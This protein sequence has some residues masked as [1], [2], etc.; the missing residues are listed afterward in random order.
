[1]N[2][3]LFPDS[4]PSGFLAVLYHD[5][6]LL[7]GVAVALLLG[8][9]GLFDLPINVP[10][11]TVGFC[12]TT[13]V[14]AAD[15]VWV[16]SPEDR[17][18]RPE[19]L[20]WIRAHEG[21]LAIETGVLVAGAG[22]ALPYLAWNTLL[23]AGALGSVAV[24][25]ALPRG[26]VRGPS[27]IYK[28]MAIA[29]VW[30]AGGALLP[31]IEAGHPLGIGALLFVGYR[32]CFILPNLLLA[33]W[34]DQVGDAA[35]GLAPWATGWT[36]HRMRGTATAFLLVAA[37][38]GAVWALVGTMPVLIAI[39]ALGPLLMIGGV[40]KLSP[41]RPRDAFLADLAVAWPL[42]PALVAWM[43]V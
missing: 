37:T 3:T 6:A 34:A 41:A 21:W 17:V 39:D 12:G 7:G 27:G 26:W 25:H 43:I 32:L 20:R 13:L 16:E 5:P 35:V 42:I 1:M 2:S 11:L 22:A 18:N 8:T 31:L 15:R 30:A 4:S 10:L 9:C 40:W 38:G 19:R 24:L 36:A 14:Y 23:W 33:D 29:A 28:P